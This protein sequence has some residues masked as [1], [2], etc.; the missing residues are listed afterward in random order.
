MNICRR[1]FVVP[2]ANND[3]GKSTIIRSMVSQAIGKRIELHKKGVRDMATPWG[4][5]ID[6]YVFGRSY[7][8]VEKNQFGSVIAALDGND[9]LWRTRE[10][11]VMPSH[12]AAN[13][14][15]DIK[16]MIDTAHAAGFDAVAVPVIHSY[17]RGDNRASL[18]PA[19]ALGWDM[20]WTIPNPWQDNPSGQLWALGNDLWSWV[21]RALTQ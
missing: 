2:L 21:S 1:L 11:I 18:S 16:D 8:E 5:R 12:V 15:S 3:H 14:I 7:Q 4:R 10:L 9:P 13:D 6:A 19:L 17:D 20:R